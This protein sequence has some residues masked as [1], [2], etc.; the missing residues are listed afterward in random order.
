MP[1][2]Y[3]TITLFPVFSYAISN[4]Q[5]LY[6][7]AGMHCPVSLSLFYRQTI[8]QPL[9]LP[10]TDHESPAVMIRPLKSPPFQSPIIEPETVMV[11]PQQL[12]LVPSTIAKDEPLIGKRVQFEY[13]AYK[14]RQPVDRFPHIGY[15]R[16]QMYL[17]Y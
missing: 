4:Q 11:P 3:R 12:Q 2:I 9:Q 15:A 14:G 16:R 8:K 5:Y 13:G 6:D 7:Y 17:P 10:A 1:C